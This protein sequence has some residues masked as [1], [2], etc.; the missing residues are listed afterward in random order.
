[1]RCK[2]CGKSEL[3][4]LDCDL[5]VECPNGI[6]QGCHYHYY[7]GRCAHEIVLQYDDDLNAQNQSAYAVYRNSEI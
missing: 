7:C 4:V 2:H 1:M 3:W 5:S 6:D